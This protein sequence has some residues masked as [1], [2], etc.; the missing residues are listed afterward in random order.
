MDGRREE[1]WNT[2]SQSAAIWFTGRD[3]LYRGILM[4]HAANREG[5]PPEELVLDQFL[6]KE[7]IRT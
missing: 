3:Y 5:K 4:L 7:L 6:I 1:R 2:M